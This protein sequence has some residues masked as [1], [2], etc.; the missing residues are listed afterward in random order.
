MANERAVGRWWPADWIA[1]LREPGLG[2]GLI[3]L[4]SPPLCPSTPLSGLHWT[5]TWSV[6][7]N[8][9][10]PQPSSGQYSFSP[11]APCLPK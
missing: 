3:Y 4:E 7:I 8:A 5:Q 1:C 6:P 9:R 11:S 2:A 10:H